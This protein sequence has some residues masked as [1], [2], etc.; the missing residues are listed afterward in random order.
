ML[1]VSAV[2]VWDDSCKNTYKCRKALELSIPVITIEYVGDSLCAGMALDFDKYITLGLRRIDQLET[3]KICGK[4]N[5]DITNAANTLIILAL[6]GY[7][8]ATVVTMSL[9]TAA[10]CTYLS[11]GLLRSVGALLCSV[12]ILQVLENINCSLL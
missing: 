11:Y 4:C 3:G 7:D 6:L 12:Y 5:G 1:K 8:G 2:L 9:D 10:Y